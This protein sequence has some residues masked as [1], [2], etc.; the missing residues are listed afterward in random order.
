LL[1]H[2]SPLGGVKTVRSTD[3]HKISCLKLISEQVIDGGEVIE[4]RILLSLSLECPGIS[5]RAAGAEGL[6]VDNGDHTV[7]MNALADGWPLEGLQE[8]SRQSQT[9]CLNDDAVELIGA[10]EQ[11]LHRGQKVV[12]NRAAQ[13]AVVELHQSTVNLIIGTEATAA[14]QITVEPDRAEFIDHHSESLAAVDEKVAEKSCF[15]GSEEACD[16]GDRK[17]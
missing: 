5:H 13:T 8:R 14:N 9:A 15:S 11:R 1:L 2:G 17:P 12:L 6:A 10:L 7:H 4:I 3:Q 16:H